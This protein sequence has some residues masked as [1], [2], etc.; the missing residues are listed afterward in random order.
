MLMPHNTVAATAPT[1]NANASVI[2]AIKAHHSELAAELS[3][4]TKAVLWAARKGDCASARE[5]LHDWY[6][7]ELLPHIVAEEQALYSPASEL[8][9]TR[10]LVC[11]ML[12]EHRALVSLV[13]DLALARAPFDVATIAASAEALFDVH[14]SKENDLLLPALDIAGLDLAVALEGMHEV[15]GHSAPS[16]AHGCGCGCDHGDA[17][18]TPVPVPLTSAPADYPPP[19]SDAR[20]LDVRMLPHGQ[21]HEIIFGKLDALNHGDA[22]VIVNDHGP[23]PLR[24]QTEALW[25]GRFAWTYLDAGPELWRL[26]IRRAG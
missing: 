22:L 26:S 7:A 12:A 9:A 11:G 21:R 6:R 3:T 1:D 13:A 5:Q 24:Y 17:T 10:L 23:K 2:D 14:L 20:E 16:Q 18:A 15:L 8:D 25:P 19:A 4:R